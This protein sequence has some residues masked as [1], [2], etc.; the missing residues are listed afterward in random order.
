MLLKRAILPLI[1]ATS[2]A[3]Q[4]ALAQS[5]EC[6]DME[7]TPPGL[8]VTTDEG[9]VF[10]VKDDQTIELA[11]GESAFANETQMTCI[12]KIP[13]FLDWPCTTDAAQSR[14][15]ATFKIEDL[16]SS[17]NR[18]KEIVQRYF[19]IPEV[20]EPIPNWLDGES[21]MSLN[22]SEIVPF[23][24]PDYWFQPNP[25]VDILDERRPRVLLISL[26]VGINR[27]VVDN[28]SVDA[29]RKYFSGA[30]IPV[31]FIFNDSNVV[32][33]SYFG[34]NVSMEEIQKAFHERKIKL[35]D[36]PMWQLGDH[37][38]SPTAE[39][40]KKLFD[41][42]DLS[43]LDP[44]RVEALK[45]QLETFGFSK[46]PVFVTL[47]EGG[48]LY[49]DDPAIVSV[50][51]SMGITRL[52]TVIIFVEQDDHLRRCG[53]GTPAGTSG[54]SGATTPPGGA[55]PPPGSVVPP[56]PPPVSDS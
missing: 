10:M 35:A 18:V 22:F 32:P 36:V 40:Y 48:G 27:V 6:K 19:E 47:L 51:L 24:S 15:F 4:V 44:I 34:A 33:I 31:V 28:F 30:D 17:D 50:A 54:V 41:L 7:G 13:E 25:A 12:R 56:P 42:P 26:F 39:E 23:S 37:H 14:K 29:L 52:P 55:N 16:Q 38:F 11:P 20:I 53:P 5:D 45:A 46:K 49:I 9:L 3:H 8:Y 1:I 21:S 2:L 43:E